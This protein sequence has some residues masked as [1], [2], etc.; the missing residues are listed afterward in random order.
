MNNV[1][2]FIKFDCETIETSAGA[3][4]ISTLTHD[5]EITVLPV[6]NPKSDKT[7]SHRIYAKSPAGYDIQVGGIWKNVSQQ[8]KEYFTLNVKDIEFRANLGR[9]P[10]QD[11]ESLQAVIGWD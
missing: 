5:L 8:K 10:D 4:R 9:F 3:G 11:D 6:T 1:T 2:N 7:P